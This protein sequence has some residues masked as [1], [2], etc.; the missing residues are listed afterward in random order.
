MVAVV[1]HCLL[2]LTSL[3]PQVGEEA[4]HATR[5]RLARLTPRRVP[6]EARHHEAQHL[7]D[8]P[9][10]LAR[11]SGT[12]WTWGASMIW[13]RDSPFDERVDV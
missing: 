3:I 5:E 7:L 2:T 8:R 6:D 13:V 11:E 10:D 1:G 4:W 12:R 9:A